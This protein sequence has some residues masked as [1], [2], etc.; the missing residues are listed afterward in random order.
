MEI[1]DLLRESFLAEWNRL[2][3]TRSAT[4]YLE[5]IRSNLAL[6]NVRTSVNE[7]IN[8]SINK[9]STERYHRQNL[10]ELAKVYAQTLYTVSGGGINLNF[11]TI[12]QAKIQMKSKGPCEA[13]PC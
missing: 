2:T 3:S 8:R 12:A 11:Q 7:S 13:Y 10:T 5:M 9:E 6:S 1:D 4:P